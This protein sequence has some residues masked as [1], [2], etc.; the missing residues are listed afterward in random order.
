MKNIS[1]AL[2]AEASEKH[3]LYE[4]ALQEAGD[5]KFTSAS[6]NSTETEAEAEGASESE[7]AEAVTEGAS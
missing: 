4:T 6:Q 7:G 3:G 5:L 2:E 1:E